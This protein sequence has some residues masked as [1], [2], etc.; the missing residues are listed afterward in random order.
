MVL[1]ALESRLGRLIIKR[2]LSPRAEPP[3]S[4]DVP[5]GSANQ[6]PPLQKYRYIYIYIYV[7][8]LL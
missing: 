4:H 7:I 8:N 5:T 6:I 1:C 3:D 2:S